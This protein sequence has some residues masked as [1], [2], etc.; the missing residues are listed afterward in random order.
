MID[1]TATVFSL[2]TI[3]NLKAVLY[4][5]VGSRRKEWTCV[6]VD[7]YLRGCLLLDVTWCV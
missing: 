2:G 5:I 4:V 7:K 6:V 3:G 1:H